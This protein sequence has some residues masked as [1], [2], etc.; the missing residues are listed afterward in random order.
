MCEHAFPRNREED[1]IEK[2]ISNIAYAGIISTE[3]DIAIVAKLLHLE[4]LRFKVPINEDRENIEF[5]GVKFPDVERI[6]AG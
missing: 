1:E 4:S 6:V 3:E 5:L 2:D